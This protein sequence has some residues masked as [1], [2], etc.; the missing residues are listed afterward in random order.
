MV[1]VAPAAIVTSFVPT[2]TVCLA[3]VGAETV[4]CTSAPKE[5]LVPRVSVPAYQSVPEIDE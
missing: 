3:M 4:V 2:E 1:C 5:S